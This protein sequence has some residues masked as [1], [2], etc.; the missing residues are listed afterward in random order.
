MSRTS[1]WS[2]ADHPPATWRSPGC[3]FLPTDTSAIT[4]P[5]AGHPG[6]PDHRQREYLLAASGELARA[7]LAGQPRHDLLQLI[8]CRARQATSAA[9][10]A[11]GTSTDGDL[12]SVDAADGPDSHRLHG[13]SIRLR[14]IAVEGPTSSPNGTRDPVGPAH[15]PS[16]ALSLGATPAGPRRVLVVLGLPEAGRVAS[17]RAL[18]GFA[19]DPATALAFADE[20]LAAEQGRLLQDRDR[21][22]AGLSELVIPPLFAAGTG[23]AGAD[24]L[25]PDRSAQA[26]ARLRQA[27]DDLD[28]AIVQVRT[29]ATGLPSPDGPLPDAVP[30]TDHAGA[31][32]GIGEQETP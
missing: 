7:L 3:R 17:T 27:A 29:V 26:R 20:R 23:L 24:G 15:R 22:A 32:A 25:L 4:A 30:T 18:R 19:E 2:A 6:S 1:R 11:V 28:Q 16:L 9:L 21:T 8:A 14:P 10:V 5:R 31:S 13:R 12:L